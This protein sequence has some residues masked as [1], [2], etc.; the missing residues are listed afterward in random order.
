MALIRKRLAVEM[1]IYEQLNELH[2]CT[3]RMFNNYYLK[4][5]NVL[6]GVKPDGFYNF[7]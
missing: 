3:V 5:A 1:W 4:T 6:N 7:P 2:G